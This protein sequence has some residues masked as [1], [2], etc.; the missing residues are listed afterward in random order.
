MA[1]FNRIFAILLKFF[2]IITLI[3]IIRVAECKRLPQIVEEDGSR[4]NNRPAGK[5]EIYLFFLNQI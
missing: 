1:Q 4:R 2:T 3:G 5:I